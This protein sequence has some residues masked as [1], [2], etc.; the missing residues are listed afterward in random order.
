[1][2]NS[3]LEVGSPVPAA[4]LEVCIAESAV[5]VCP[6]AWLLVGGEDACNQLKVID[7]P[8]N[9]HVPFRDATDVLLGVDPESIQTYCERIVD[10][11]AETE[12]GPASK[13]ISHF[14]ESTDVAVQFLRVGRTV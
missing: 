7:G 12:V 14:L 8:L 1:M 10:E 6:V 4:E 13:V 3:R 5:D 11:C 2:A 9:V